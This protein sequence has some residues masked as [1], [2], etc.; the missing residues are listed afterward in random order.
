[1]LGPFVVF[2]LETTGFSPKQ[3]RIVEIGA[4]RIENGQ[5]IDTFESFIAQDDLLPEFFKD[6]T[7][8]K[9]EDLAGALALP[10]VITDFLRFAGEADWVAHNASFDLSFMSEALEECGYNAYSGM[11]LC[12][13]ELSQLLLPR[14]TSYSLESLAASH[15]IGHG[16]PHRALSDALATAELFL[17]LLDKAQNL[18]L[19]LLQ[20]LE[21]LS[22]MS[23]RSMRHFFTELLQQP[24]KLAQTEIPEGV[25]VIQQ[26]M[27]KPL[28]ITERNLAD[29]EPVPF[30]PDDAANILSKEGPLSVKFD[31]YEERPSQLQMAKAVG[32]ALS[33]NHHLIVEAGTGTGKSLAYLV[34][35][36]LHSSATGERVVVATHTINLQEQLKQ[37]DIPL[38]K[39]ILNVPFEV[40]VLKGRNNYVCMRKVAAGINSQGIVTDSNERLFYSRMVTWLVETEAGDREELNLSGNQTDYW[41]RVASETD[42][43]ISKKCPWFRN[44]YYFKNRAAAEQADVVVTN[45]SLVFS[46]IKSDHRVLPGYSNLIV[47]EAHHMEDE[48]TKHLG[49]DA[50]YH[51]FIAA[52]NRLVR[53]N[54]QG[55]LVQTRTMLALQTELAGMASIL[56]QMTEKALELRV[57]A[58]ETFQL[59]RQFTLE[60]AE[61]REAGRATLRLS[62][63]HFDLPDWQAI[64]SSFENL[65]TEQ[66]LLRSQMQK[67]ELEASEFADDEHIA[68]PVTDINGQVQELDRLVMTMTRFFRETNSVASVVLWLEAEDRGPRPFIGIYM[69]PVKVG[70]LLHENLFSKKDSVVLTSATI[71]IKNGFS[72]MIDR[73]GLTQSEKAGLLKTLQAD[74]PFDYKNQALLCVPTDVMPVKG[75]AEEDFIDSLCESISSLARISNGRMLVLFTSHKMLRA[76]YAKVKP[77]LAEHQIR[78]FAHG[79]DSSSR[80]RL[81]HEFQKNKQAVLF[82]ANSFWEGIDIPGDDLS[83]LVIVRLPFWPPNHPVAEART[84]ALEKEG[85]NAFMEYSV[86]QAIVRFKQ[87]FGRVIRT[88][89]DIGA[90]VVYDRRLVDARYGRHFIKSLPDP[91]VYQGPEREVWKVV[92]NWL[93]R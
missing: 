76:A 75:V 87:G 60:H 78:V 69:A 54:R 17:Q 58:E 25:T 44:C 4:V 82:G 47:D 13:L 57:K 34:P 7:G 8:I 74:S 37:R 18:P 22:P 16:A 59:L 91:W 3:D 72:Y 36:I 15:G 65:Q 10:N 83:L 32:V 90:I 41:S 66:S 68:N 85:R 86:P 21:Q 26:L 80:S 6:L 64:L 70:P 93:K 24:I 53:D 62:S 23:E 77:K 63:Q 27:H 73:L 92:Y 45:H 1:M 5:I 28:Q 52:L 9:E 48:A 11:Y 61:K 46:D 31:G 19:M 35:A 30:E 81:V 71:T 38:L 20:Q 49:E 88:K 67:L 39:E 51:Q 50:N 43:C 14:E 33:E 29:R 89:K 84:E 79:V 40:S 55:Q 2:D 56:D 42:S 12:T